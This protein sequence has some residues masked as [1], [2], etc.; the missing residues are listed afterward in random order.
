MSDEP[1][2][3]VRK[4]PSVELDDDDGTAEVLL[5]PFGRPV[6]IAEVQPGRGLVRY[7]EEMMPGAAERAI[8]AGGGRLPFVY[9]HSDSFADRLG[10]ATRLWE[11]EVGT[12]AALRFDRSK[13]D[14]VR[15]ALTTSH[16]AIS[17]AFVS[18]V[19]RPFTEREGSLVQRR[20][21][22]LKHVAAVTAGAYDE[23]RI[24]AVRNVADEL[25]EAET[26]PERAEREAVE[27][28]RRALDEA[29]RLIEAGK[30]WD[31]WR[32]A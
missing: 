27:A 3:Y 22:I 18:R 6:P 4:V 5:F 24:I 8:R 13:L 21:I 1:T 15:D 19:P 12:Y 9:D 29:D 2:F 10:V 14:A 28:A 16:Q 32:Q 26:E 11:N 31:P 23:A 30:R 7:T 20:S 25:D 17:V